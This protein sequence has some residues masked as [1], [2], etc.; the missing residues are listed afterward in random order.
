VGQHGGVS[1]DAAP[2]RPAGKGAQ[3]ALATRTALVDLAAEMFAEQGYVQTSIRDI[4][5]RASV[6]SGAIYGHFRNKADLLVEAI[7]TRT[8]EQ[9][10]AEAMGLGGDNDY[11]ETLTRLARDHPRR[12]RLRALLLQ[13]AAAAQTDAET[14]ER[15]RAEQLAH[16]NVWLEGYERDRE[17]LGIDPSV[18]LEVAVTFTWAV[19]LGLGALEAIGIEPTSEEGWADVFNRLARSLQLPPDNQERPAPARRR[20]RKKA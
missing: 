11:I 6:T 16:L 4:A 1:D 7:N 17:R 2:A 5:R 20:F 13:G 15:L 14:R 9:L 12:R 10:E 18:D 19:E 3:K 8:A